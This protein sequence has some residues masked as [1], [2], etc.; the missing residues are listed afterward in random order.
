M[1][2]HLHALY[3]RALICTR[4]WSW[5]RACVEQTWRLAVLA[6][7][8]QL[9]DANHSAMCSIASLPCEGEGG[10]NERTRERC[11]DGGKSS[12]KDRNRALLP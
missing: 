10:R 1:A 9:N 6:V 11:I 2:F 12:E 4:V 7:Y 8:G 5:A 3:S